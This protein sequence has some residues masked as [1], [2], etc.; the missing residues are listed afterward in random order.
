M[1]LLQIK[2]V[3][4]QRL[5]CLICFTAALALLAYGGYEFYL[6]HSDTALL[7]RIIGSALLFVGMGLAPKLFF[8]PVSQIVSQ[9]E[10]TSIGAKVQSGIFNVGIFLIV[11]SFLWGWFYP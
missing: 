4:K 3:T 6:G 1:G 8:M 2:S 10:D 5:V 9:K 11:C 7:L